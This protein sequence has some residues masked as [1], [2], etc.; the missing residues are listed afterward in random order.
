MSALK[1]HSAEGLLD[2]QMRLARKELPEK[3]YKIL[4]NFKMR[5]LSEG[6]TKLRIVRYIGLL[7]K[8]YSLVPRE[9]DEWDEEYIVEVLAKLEETDYENST[10]NEFKKAMKKFIKFYYGK[11]SDLLDYVKQTRKKDS[12]IPEVI[13]EEDILKLIEVADNMRDKAMIAVCYEAGLRVGELA[14]LRIRDIEFFTNSTGE[15]RAKIKVTGKTGER[16]IPIVMSVPYLKRW[17]D[18]HPFRDDPNAYVFCSLARINY[19]GMISYQKLYEKFIELGKKA[20]LKIRLHPH[21]LRHSRATVLANHLTEA[22]MCEFFGWVQG[23]DMPRIYVHLSGRDVEKSIL[24]LYGLETE[25][26]KKEVEAKPKKCPRCGYLNAPTD[27]YCGRCALI[28][29]ES[30]RV[31]LEMEEMKLMKEI[32]GMMDPETLR[33]A[34]DMIEF[35]ERMRENPELFNLLLQVKG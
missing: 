1:F 3:S 9:F 27:F 35:V 25:E 17:L 33:R 32:M 2:G 18:E 19:G 10:K 8:I 26:Q 20:G 29:D 5:L 34:K 7:R 31:E 28:L 22:Q 15:M 4:E 24:K 16:V 11:K 21:T 14:G 23:S 30:K 12:K 13:R 6:I